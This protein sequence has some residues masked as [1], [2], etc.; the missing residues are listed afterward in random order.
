MTACR[1]PSL[2][3]DPPLRRIAASC[4][5]WLAI[6]ISAA[7][8]CMSGALPVASAQTLPAL[9]VRPLEITKDSGVTFPIPDGVIDGSHDAR[10][11]D[12]STAKGL[13]A[14]DVDISNLRWA[15]DCRCLRHYVFYVRPRGTNVTTRFKVKARPVGRFQD[16]W[17]PV[18]F[19]MEYGNTRDTGT[20]RLPFL[21][22]SPETDLLV[23]SNRDQ[24]QEV[25]LHGARRLRFVLHNPLPDAA[26]AVQLP[27]VLRGDETLWRTIAPESTQA[28][29]VT[30]PGGRQRTI[31]VIVQPEPVAAAR[32]SLP[33]S[34]PTKVHTTIEAEFGYSNASVQGRADVLLGT[35]KVRFAPGLGVLLIA[36][37]AGVS[38][39]AA[40]AFVVPRLARPG[41]KR[42]RFIASALLAALVLELV[43]MFLVAQNSR[44]VLFG[45]DLDPWQTLPTALVGI[46]AGIL[47]SRV[48]DI[49]PWFKP[50][51]P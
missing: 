17:E 13:F 48:A 16:R 8:L 3:T 27:P 5:V 40:L 23:Q 33:P 36:L 35:A 12:D 6:A 22:Q 43:G 47:G 7:A 32:A 20:V 42:V 37:L 14:F 38:L 24:I 21:A 19:D 45:F 51:T 10:Q 41:T 1:A 44:F 11:L 15:E 31:D 46:G 50:A 9:H 29:T 30:I 28:S 34:L 18:S 25:N 39:G 26:I 4:P 49:I 2:S